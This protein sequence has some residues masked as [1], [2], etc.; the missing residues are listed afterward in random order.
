M[1]LRINVIILVLAMASESLAC[2]CDQP[3][4][5]ESFKRSD[6]ILVGK[7]VSQ[8]LVPYSQTIN[9]DSLT[10]LRARIKDDERLSRWMDMDYIF[11]VTIQIENKYKG[12]F[13]D[14]TVVIYTAML[15]ASCGYRFVIGETYF[16]HAYKKDPV[17]SMF[18]GDDERNQRLGRKNTFWTTHCTRTSEYSESD[19][20]VLEA[21]KRG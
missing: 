3:T 20:L 17:A 10:V 4:L 18:V 21:L 12:A 14:D 11:K 16:V 5:T 8:E 2:K 1:I 19:A 9:P 15:S 7:V 13:A 6:L